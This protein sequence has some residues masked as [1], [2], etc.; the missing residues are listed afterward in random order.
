MPD[1]VTPVVEYA[2]PVGATTVISNKTRPFISAYMMFVGISGDT[3]NAVKAVVAEP[4]TV[5]IEDAGVAAGGIHWYRLSRPRGDKIAIKAKDAKGTVVASFTLSVIELPKGSGPIELEVEPGDPKHPDRINLRFYNPKN[6][7]DWIDKRMEAIGYNIYL[8]GFQVYCTGMSPPIEV[9]YS[10][11]DLTLNEAEPIDSTVYDTLAAAN[12]AIKKVPAKQGV[13]RFAYYW[14]AGGEVIAPT[15]F[16]PATSP[17]IIATFYEARALYADY[18]IHSLTGIAIGIVAG[19]ALRSVLGR[20]YRK[21]SEDPVPP[22]RPPP[23]PTPNQI[24]P[25]NDTVNVG[26]TG[27]IADVTNVNPIKPGSGGQSSGIPNHVPAP[28]EKMDEIFVPGSVKTMYSQR[29][30]YQDVDWPVATRAAAKVM[31]KGG[32]VQMNIWTQ[33]QQEVDALKTAFEKALKDIKAA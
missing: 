27:E 6:D 26:G 7:A 13:T 15:V 29:L 12:E 21:S 2:A 25:V 1:F 33:S 14:G 11:V 5:T 3:A 23:A 16:S 8:G 18:V 22:R 24:R 9:P 30:R 28:M 32:K 10:L 17:R 31:P 19:M 20:I 4:S